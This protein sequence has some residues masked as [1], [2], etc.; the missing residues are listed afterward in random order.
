MNETLKKERKQLGCGANNNFLIIIQVFREYEVDGEVLALF[1]DDASQLATLFNEELGCKL[2]KPTV[3]KI[4][5]IIHQAASGPS[6]F[7]GVKTRGERG[8]VGGIFQRGAGLQ[9]MPQQ[10]RYVRIIA[11]NGQT[12]HSAFR[13]RRRRRRV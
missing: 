7:T 3:H 13:R 8:G 10:T 6:A 9:V 5:S 1:M 11:W 12:S 2:S 4:Y